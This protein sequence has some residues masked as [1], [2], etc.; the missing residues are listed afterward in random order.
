MSTTASEATPLLGGGGVAPPVLTWR[1]HVFNFLEAK[2]P[3]GR[4]YEW[5]TV[6]LI[7][8]NVFAFILGSL[9]VEKYN[10]APWAARDGGICD[11]T[12][13]GLLFG[14]YD[15]NILGPLGLGATS[16]LEIIT[17]AVFTVDY[18]FRVYCADLES[19]K[20]GGFWGR[21][22]YIPTFYSIVDLASTVPFYFDSFI[23]VNADL[24]ASQVTTACTY[25]E[26]SSQ[27]TH[28]RIFA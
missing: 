1:D 28:T 11:K 19:D 16:V 23:L 8:L 7:V 15:D 3:A 27:H 25:C 10:S 9:F 21:V 13:D 18:L 14:N 20:F 2:T 4:V 17:V 24:A 26:C 12:C 22:R 5:V 6:C